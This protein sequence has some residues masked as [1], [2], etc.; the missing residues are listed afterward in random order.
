[1]FI[2]PDEDFEIVDTGSF[3]QTHPRIIK[4]ADNR[5]IEAYTSKLLFNSHHYSIQVPLL[6][7]S[8]G[9]TDDG[10]VPPE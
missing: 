8:K 3:R 9:T 2:A 10:V 6:R 1:M 5:Q 7:G 4:F